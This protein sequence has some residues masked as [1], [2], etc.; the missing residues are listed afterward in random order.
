MTKG[1][2]LSEFAHDVRA[3]LAGE[4]VVRSDDD[5]C[6]WT[7]NYGR[8]SLAYRH[9]QPL[10]A[11]KIMLIAAL[12]TDLELELQDYKIDDPVDQR[13]RALR[14]VSIRGSSECRV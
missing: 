2:L 12:T 14:K 3:I 4:C 5:G 7:I 13:D 11:N 8:V 9:G 10:S 6:N 1:E